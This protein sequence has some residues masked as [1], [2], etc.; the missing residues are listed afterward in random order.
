[1]N[2][3][4]ASGDG[5][6][7]A[8]ALIAIGLAVGVAVSFLRDKRRHPYEACPKC[9]GRAR[10]WSGWTRGAWGRCPACKGSGSRLRH[11]ARKPD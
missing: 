11:G 8:G 2:A 4:A 9:Q 5:S 10:H 6:P 7:V 3:L 1:M